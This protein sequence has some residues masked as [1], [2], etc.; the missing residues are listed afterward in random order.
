[1]HKQ[2]DTD[3]ICIYI[4]RQIQIY[5][6]I[7]ERDFTC[8]NLSGLDPGHYQRPIHSGNHSY[9]RSVHQHPACYK[10]SSAWGLKNRAI[11]FKEIP[12]HNWGY[13]GGKSGQNGRSEIQTANQHRPR[14]YTCIS[15]VHI[16][17]AAEFDALTA[18]YMIT[19]P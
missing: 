17:S 11:A 5:I 19:L 1:M 2:L 8:K 18:F 14:I 16:A 10:A 15:C 3:K 4:Q 13:G 9:R 12:T 6:Y 7:Y